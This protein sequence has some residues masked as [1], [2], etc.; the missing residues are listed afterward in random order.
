VYSILSL[1]GTKIAFDRR[2]SG[3]AVV[4]VDGALCSRRYGPMTQLSRLLAKDF[5]VLSYDRRGRGDSGNQPRYAV[6]REI[7]DLGCLLAECDGPVSV[8]G[9]S[10]GAALAL[11]SVTAGLPISRLALY[12]PPYGS[13]DEAHR[14]ALR[15]Y[16]YRLADLLAAG[17][18][19][20]AIELFLGLVDVPPE[21][22]AMLR[23]TSRWTVLREL[24]P[25]LAY[26]SAVLDQR[27]LAGALPLELL[28]A[29]EVPTLVLAGGASSAAM[30]ETAMR[31]GAAL[32][33][34]GYRR[35]EHQ[36]HDVDPAVLAPVLAGFFGG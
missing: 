12:E 22:V 20:T 3:P 35:L 26:D 1:D 13:G 5:T 21:V 29:V 10:A 2:G 31:L 14:E 4:L 7:E 17:R 32:P 30:R 16:P 6:E 36:V 8:F 34:G 25:T 18:F 23:R 33:D 19:E 9:R 15:E 11:R 28:A 24:A 27:R